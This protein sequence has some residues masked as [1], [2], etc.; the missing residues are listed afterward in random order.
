MVLGGIMEAKLRTSLP[1]LK[2]PWDLVNRPIAAIIF[3]MIVLAIALHVWS[4]IRA[5]RG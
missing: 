1:R 4:L 2:E 5:R 3:S